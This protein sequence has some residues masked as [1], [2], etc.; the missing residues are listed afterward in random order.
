MTAVASLGAVSPL[1]FTPAAALAAKA[2]TTDLLELWLAGKA[3]GTR[4]A[5]DHAL[6]DFG[7]WALGE[8][9]ATP[10]TTLATLLGAGHA[11]AQRLALGWAA[12]LQARGL[13]PRTIT[14]ML[15]AVSSLVKMAR[16]AG[17]VTWRL[18][19]LP[20]SNEARHDRSGPKRHHV[21]ALVEHL[22]EL[23]PDPAAVRDLA[24]VRLL[25]GAGLRRAE[26]CAL[27]V[28]HVVAGAVLVKRKGRREL[29]QL[30]IG[31]KAE[32]ALRAWLE[33]RGVA[34]GAVFQRLDRARAALSCH[35]GRMSGEAVRLMLRARAKACGI[36]T[37]V[38]PHGLRHRG[39]TDAE[40]AGYHEL[41]AFG[42]WS[43]ANSAKQYLD[44]R[45]D[46]R[47]RAITRVEV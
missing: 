20:S 15:S 35:P 19:A 4:R 26:L 23:V 47:A 8:L 42:G 1:R 16:V 14:R 27:D 18:E 9:A 31:P 13:A 39:A 46:A 34:P 45:E 28:E 2:S 10:A 32:A 5:Y 24:I 40:R 36:R 6:T 22:E 44:D 11:Q 41:L 12:D 17:L 38:R 7:R 37:T 33:V 21:A 29:T 30:S 25:H 43:S 3:R